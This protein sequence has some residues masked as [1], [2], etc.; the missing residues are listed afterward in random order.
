MVSDF[1]ARARDRQYNSPG[2]IFYDEE[3]RKKRDDL[4]FQKGQDARQANEWAID[5][6]IRKRNTALELQRGDI[7]GKTG[8]EE[9]RTAGDLEK[10]QLANTGALARQR[11]ASEASMYGADQGLRGDELRANAIVEST[12][13][14]RKTPGQDAYEAW[15]KGA[16]GA[17]PEDHISAR[18]K[19]NILDQEPPDDFSAFET[20]APAAAPQA[21]AMPQ[22]RK[23]MDFVSPAA[24]ERRALL[25]R[26]K[27]VEEDMFGKKKDRN[28]F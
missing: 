17:S 3:Q 27:K 15:A 24:A 5:A 18:K 16:L 7:F 2:N 11:L 13:G 1:Q 10:Q 20:K 21:A 14:K 4:L 28:W 12:H 6:D 25:K 8:L 9:M 23:S 26:N 22:G 19:F